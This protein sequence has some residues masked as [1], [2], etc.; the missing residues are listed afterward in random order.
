MN[1]VLSSFHDAYISEAFCR[2]VL[3]TP[4][5][6]R[7]IMY[8]TF[9]EINFIINLT[10]IL[11][12]IYRYFPIFLLLFGGIGNSLSCLVFLQR[13]LRKN[14][15]ALYFLAASISNIVYLSTLTSTM[16]DA[17]DETFNLMNTVSGVC[18]FTM[19]IILM[20]RTLSLWFIVLATIDRYLVS[21]P[22]ENRRQMSSLKR[23]HQ[24]IIIGCVLTLLMWGETFYCFDANLIG[25]PLKCFTTSSACRFYNDISVTLMSILIPSII[26]LIFGGLTI[27]NIH[28]SRE[29]INP[30]MSITNALPSRSRKTEQNLTRMLLTQI[31]LIVILNLPQAIFTFY[32][33]ITF[34]QPKTPVQGTLN[35]FIFNILLLFP[36][37]SCSISFLLYT[38]AGKIFRQT[39]VEMAQKVVNFLTCYRHPV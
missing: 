15:C 13:A 29:R 20:S 9:E 18:K 21:S 6:D 36:F 22:D 32:L 14:P 12:Q 39:F 16:L 4:R 34:D 17:W 5:L 8:P 35:G 27:A 28:R 30:S 24:S 33:T 10:N 1:I 37:I 38:L 3:I 2:S 31:L 7:F 19:L 25:T 26:M 23:S 11:K